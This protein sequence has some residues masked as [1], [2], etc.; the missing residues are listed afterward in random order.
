LSGQWA[1]GYTEHYARGHA[2]VND[3]RVSLIG[4]ARAY[5]PSRKAAACGTPRIAGPMRPVTFVLPG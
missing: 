5:T 3:Y 2:S 4:Q 1:T